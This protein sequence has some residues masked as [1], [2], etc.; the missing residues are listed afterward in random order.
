YSSG[1][2]YSLL[3]FRTTDPTNYSN[4]NGTTWL[5]GKAV[6]SSDNSVTRYIEVN[7][8]GVVYELLARQKAGTPPGI[9]TDPEIEGVEV[10]WLFMGGDDMSGM[11]T[12]E[13]VN[14]GVTDTMVSTS[15]SSSGTIT[16]DA[17]TYV[18]V[19][20]TNDEPMTPSP[21]TE[22]MVETI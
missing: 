19:T 6:N 16:A 17:G 1:R 22:L 14:N 2:I 15:T 11:L 13:Y 9:P 10:D 5:L 8:D 3:G 4:V 21:E 7:I 12:L 20:V 18:K